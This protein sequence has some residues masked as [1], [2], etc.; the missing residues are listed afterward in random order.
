MSIALADDS[1]RR[2]YER[3]TARMDFGK[4][5]AIC[6][7]NIANRRHLLARNPLRPRVVNALLRGKLLSIY[8]EAVI[9]AELTDENVFDIA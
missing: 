4:E 2:N 6:R 5:G 3:F 8:F 9:D 7:S 1:G